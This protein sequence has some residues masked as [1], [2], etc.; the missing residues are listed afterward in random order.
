M[1]G[2]GKSQDMF[3][4]YKDHFDSQFESQSSKP[5]KRDLISNLLNRMTP[6]L[7]NI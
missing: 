4:V 7:K 3:N 6:K 5:E 1:L 2:N